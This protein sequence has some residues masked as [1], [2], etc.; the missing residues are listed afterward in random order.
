MQ[1]FYTVNR[2]HSFVHETDPEIENNVGALLLHSDIGDVACGEP[3]VTV[4]A[5][6]NL[7]RSLNESAVVIDKPELTCISEEKIADMDLL[8]ATSKAEKEIA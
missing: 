3:D 1:D 5:N 8:E 2:R 7:L 6:G 4:N